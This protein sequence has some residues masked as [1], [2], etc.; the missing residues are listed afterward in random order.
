[1][2]VALAEVHH[3]EASCPSTPTVRPL[4]LRHQ[5][6]EHKDMLRLPERVKVS[7]GRGGEKQRMPRK[8]KKTIMSFLLAKQADRL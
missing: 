4:R 7:G 3:E 1:M 2:S 8:E 6:F 5:L